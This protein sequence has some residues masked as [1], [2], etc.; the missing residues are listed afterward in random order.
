MLTFAQ[1]GRVS[2][3]LVIFQAFNEER[4][5][6]LHLL[7]DRLARP[8]RDSLARLRMPQVERQKNGASPK[9]VSFLKIEE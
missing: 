8:Y 2:G 6:L 5:G 3:S 4:A 7:A 9:I 1:E